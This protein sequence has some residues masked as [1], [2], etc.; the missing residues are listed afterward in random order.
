MTYDFNGGAEG[1]LDSASMYIRDY[2]MYVFGLAVVLIGIMIWMYYSKKAEVM[3][4][5]GATALFKLGNWN[6]N[7]DASDPMCSMEAVR[8]S[9]DAWATYASRDIVNGQ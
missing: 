2:S 1:F 3:Y 9:D 7:M 6:E 4:N 5:P 8:N